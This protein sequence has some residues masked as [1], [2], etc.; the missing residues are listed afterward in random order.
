MPS[1]SAP[2]GDAKP[3]LHLR[4]LLLGTRGGFPATALTVQASNSVFLSKEKNMGAVYNPYWP[5]NI[6]ETNFSPTAPESGGL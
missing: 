6:S 4:E 1:V 2:M 5:F 3:G